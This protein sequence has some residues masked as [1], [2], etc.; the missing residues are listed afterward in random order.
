MCGDL[1]SNHGTESRARGASWK[2]DAA[3]IDLPTAKHPSSGCCRLFGGNPQRNP[4]PPALLFA[5]G[6][7]PAIGRG[8][9]A[10]R[11]ALFRLRAGEFGEEREKEVKKISGKG[12][13]PK[14]EGRIDFLF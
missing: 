4:P 7:C 14:F 8:D 1:V 9:A 2:D 11:G 6:T 13:A 5:F 3:S 12:I 10:C